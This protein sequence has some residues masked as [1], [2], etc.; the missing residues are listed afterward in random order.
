MV[1]LRD[2]RYGGEVDA[3]SQ[4]SLETYLRCGLRWEFEYVRGKH[5][6]V[7]REMAVGTGVGSGAEHDLSLKARLMPIATACEIRDAA[8]A[9][10]E[11][12]VATADHDMGRTEIS[13]GLSD[14][15]SG[16]LAYA[17]D[18]A[19]QIQFVVS[20]EQTYAADYPG[21]RLIGSPD[22]VTPDGIG[23]LKTGK[24]WSQAE[25][26]Y[27]RQLTA[28]AIL[29]EAHFGEF[30]SRVWIDSLSK[31]KDGWAYVRRW[32][33]RGPEH[34]KAFRFVAEAA[35][36]QVQAGVFLPAPQGAW[37]C[38]RRWCPHYSY[39]PAVAGK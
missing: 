37:W 38:E 32:S 5:R 6:R 35:L 9:G 14:V 27:S 12:E 29:Y 10:Y 23:D 18:V 8:V 15:A 7:T 11:A 34:A 39:C 26:D 13:V 30:P 22:Y 20:A 21:W 31:R 4:S 25:A 17:L 2:P 1:D 3:W 36:Q 33:H 19:P 28:Y 24:S 16:A